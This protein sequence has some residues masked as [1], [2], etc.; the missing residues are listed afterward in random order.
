VRVDLLLDPFGTRWA[1]V[2]DAAGAAVDAGFAGIWTYDHLDGRVYDADDVLEGWTVLSALAAVV[3]EVV[4]GPMVLN[5]AN[6]QPGVLAVMAATLQDVS[7]GRLLLG[8]G[9]GA[10][11]GTP[12]AREQEAVGLPVYGDADRRTDVERCVAEL[13]RV[14]RTPR[15]L[16]PDPEPPL[17]IAALG[18]KMAAVA[19][20]IGD[21]INAQA[22]DPRLPD[23][24]AV[25]LDA[26]RR[27]GRDD[28]GFLVT[29]FAGFDERWL[30]PESPDRL[31]LAALGVHRL[32]LALTA[33][34]DR[35]RITAAGRLL[36]R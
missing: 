27:A 4:L 13:R 34:F 5:V 17:V 14:W 7:G 11:P 1:E 30:S 19:G 32:V 29:L 6:R 10:R 9:A 3:P 15:F 24:L 16:R 8:L 12:Y 33:P 18:L 22:A 31:E 25:A 26:Y 21:G 20:R 28:G 36:A 35:G 2:R 23:L